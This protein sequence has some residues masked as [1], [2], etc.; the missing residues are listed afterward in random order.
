MGDLLDICARLPRSAPVARKFA[1][2]FVNLRFLRRAGQALFGGWSTG[3]EQVGDEL[4]AELERRIYEMVLRHVD[5]V[6]QI[7]VD[8][9]DELGWLVTFTVVDQE[10]DIL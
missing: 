5:G 9:D 6:S 2:H 8:L 1:P 7:Q 4:P 3:G 10:Q